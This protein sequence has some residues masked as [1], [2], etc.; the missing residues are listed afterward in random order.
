[1]RAPTRNRRDAQHQRAAPAHGC[2]PGRRVVAGAPRARGGPP[3][4]RRASALRP[5]RSG[6]GRGT[7]HRRRAHHSAGDARVADVARRRARGHRR[8]GVAGAA[9]SRCAGSGATT[10]TGELRETSRSLPGRLPNREIHFGSS[11]RRRSARSR[12]CA[13]CGATTSYRAAQRTDERPRVNTARGSGA[14]NIGPCGHGRA[15]ERV[16][17][18]GGRSAVSVCP[19]SAR[20]D[21]RLDHS[22]VAWSAD[23]GCRR[24]TRIA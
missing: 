8:P 10:W 5:R 7:P 22:S 3:R 19:H 21:P 24:S 18:V 11:R 20:N 2:R 9:G 4:A 12:R 13:P 15:V 16:D 23:A 1:M 6:A 17:G 14:R